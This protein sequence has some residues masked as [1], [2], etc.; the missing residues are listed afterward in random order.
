MPVDVVSIPGVELVRVGIHEI[1][2]GTWAVS[3]EDLTDAVAAHKAGA[4]RD[5]VVKLGH[6]GP[7]AGGA[8]ALG[9]VRNLRT[10]Q[11]GDVL[12]GDF[13][14][15]PR[16]LAAV[17][18]KAW[19]QRSVE[20]LVDFVAD[21]GTTYGF[22]LTAVALLGAVMPG[23]DGLADIADVAALYGVAAWSGRRVVVAS[24]P[25]GAGVPDSQRARAVAVARARRTRTHRLT[26]IAAT[27]A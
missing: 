13:T 19:P 26:T 16:A 24:V 6:E 27:P 23:V 8:P 9:R 4:V 25:A 18:P 15:V 3:R 20:G 10:T 5:A 14:D 12:L 7:L 11:G 1:S 17:M 21:D 2:T 22:V